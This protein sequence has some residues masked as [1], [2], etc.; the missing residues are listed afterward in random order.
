MAERVRGA[1]GPGAARGGPQS[2]V[3]LWFD[4]SGIAALREGELSRAQGTLVRSQA[5][6]AFVNAGFTRESAIAAAESGDLSQLVPDPR[7]TP[8]GVVGRETATSREVVTPNG[9]IA[10]QQGPGVI[11]GRP[12]QAGVPQRLPGV[13][14]P[15]LPNAIPAGSKPMPSLPNGARG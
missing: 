10:P 14:T 9:Q 5:L 8:P 13:G 1:G 12:P 11:P 4:V 3:R 2:G 7:A 15:N 6:A